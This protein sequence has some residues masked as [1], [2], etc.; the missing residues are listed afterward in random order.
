MMPAERLICLPELEIMFRN[1]LSLFFGIAIGISGVFLHNAYQPVGLI[2]SGIALILATYLLREMYRSRTS[3]L[4]FA[5]GW[6]FIVIRGAT[7]GNGDEL[8]VEGNFYGTWLL[9]GGI[10]WL[11]VAFVRSSKFD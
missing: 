1:L 11:L 4:L 6:L 5:A 10:A 3:F 2:V 7:T 9:L 8:L